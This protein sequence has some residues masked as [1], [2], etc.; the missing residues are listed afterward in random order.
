MKKLI[1]LAVLISTQTFASSFG[2]S[3]FITSGNICKE[4]RDTINDTQNYILSGQLSVSLQQ[5][6]IDLKKQNAELSTEEALD[7][8][9]SNAEEVI[10]TTTK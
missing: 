7:L 1:V 2:A 4:A 3:S 10:R 5:K 9:V 8:L 6:L